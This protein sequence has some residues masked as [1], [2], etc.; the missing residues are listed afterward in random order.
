[1][2]AGAHSQQHACLPIANVHTNDA[3]RP[4]L[5]QA[6]SEAACGDAS[7]KH[8]QALHAQP[9]GPEGSLQLVPCP[10][11][12]ASNASQDRASRRHA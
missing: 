6:V 10:A 12:A 4:V 7:I 8:P 2:P 3:G 5:Q 9:E 1:M 11:P